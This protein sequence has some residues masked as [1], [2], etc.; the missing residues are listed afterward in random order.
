MVTIVPLRQ[1]AVAFINSHIVRFGQFRDAIVEVASEFRL[2]DPANVSVS[3]VHRDVVEVV[4]SAE[5][6]HLAEFCHSGQ[7]CESDQRILAFHH[8]VKPLKFPP[9]RLHQLWI[10]DAVD[11]RLLIFINKDDNTFPR[12]FVCGFNGSLESCREIIGFIVDSISYFPFMQRMIKVRVKIGCR[13]ISASSEVQVKDGIRCPVLFKRFDIQPFEQF[14]LPT[15]VSLPSWTPA[16][17]SQTD[18]AGSGSSISQWRQADRPTWSCQHKQTLHRE[19]WK[20]FEFRSDI[21]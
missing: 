10:V 9:E 11:D 3:I 4:Q 17:S 19:C 6:A 16:D 8:A 7:E 20:S 5:Y 2:R 13:S 12:F 1:F 14:L 18:A 21:T 15:E